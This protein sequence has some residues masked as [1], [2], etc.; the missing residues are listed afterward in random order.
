MALQKS[1]GG[2]AQGIDQFGAA[3]AVVGFH[4]KG[5]QQ[6]SILEII[7]QNRFLSGALKELFNWGGWANVF[8]KNSAILTVVCEHFT[9]YMLLFC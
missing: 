1:K 9:N 3:D 7:F 6:Q 5:I 4:A 8:V 2:P